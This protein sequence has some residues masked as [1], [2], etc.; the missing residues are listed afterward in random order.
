M[1]SIAEVERMLITELHTNIGKIKAYSAL[2][3]YNEILG[4]S[5]FRIS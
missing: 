5:S 3:N 2:E 1:K 4:D